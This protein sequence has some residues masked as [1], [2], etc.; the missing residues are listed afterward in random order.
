MLLRKEGGYR[1][2][3]QHVD[4]PGIKAELLRRQILWTMVYDHPQ[5]IREAAFTFS[6]L[7]AAEREPIIDEALA[8]W[9]PSGPTS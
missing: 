3:S 8:S 4:V 9:L 6:Y 5:D 2:A 1:L 7:S